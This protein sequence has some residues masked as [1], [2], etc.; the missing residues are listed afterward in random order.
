MLSFACEHCGRDMKARPENASRAMH[1]PGCMKQVIVPAADAPRPLAPTRP[2]KGRA[3]PLLVGLVLVLTTAAA[4]LGWWYYGHEEYGPNPSPH[5]EADGPELGDLVFLPADAQ[6]VATIRAAELDKMPATKQALERLRKD[7]PDQADPVARMERDVGLKPSEIERLHAVGADADQQLGW[8]VAKTLQPL[9]RRKIL[10]RLKGRGEKR[11]EGRRYYLGKNLDGET[12]AVHFAS[13]NVLVVSNAAGIELA[14]AQAVKPVME[15][16]LRASIG[17][18]E[19]SKSQVI[20]GLY[21]GGGGTKALAADEQARPLAEVKLARITLDADEAEATLRLVADAG[22]EGKAKRLQE[23][24]APALSALKAKGILFRDE[25]SKAL[26]AFAD[27]AKVETK[28]PELHARATT[29]PKSMALTMAYLGK[30]AMAR[31]RK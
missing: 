19:T 7:D 21:P 22:D 20:V 2:A 31:A 16:P 15:G 30:M 1:C 27:A 13:A 11:H 23:G 6:M 12:I 3:V 5:V 10:D 28:G 18:V 24:L 8:A 14:L 29:D 25:E 17:T 26:R 9:S 4:A